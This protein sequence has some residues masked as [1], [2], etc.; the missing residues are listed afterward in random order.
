MP[1]RSLL[2]RTAV[3]S[4]GSRGIGLASESGARQ[5]ANVVLLAKTD[6]PILV[7]PGPSTHRGRRG[8][9]RRRPGARGRR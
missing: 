9:G 6:T 8:R 5:G 1:N 7:C 2:E 3:I 4:G